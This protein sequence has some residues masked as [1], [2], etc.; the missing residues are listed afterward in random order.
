MIQTM[1]H[2]SVKCTQFIQNESH[3]HVILY[4]TMQLCGFEQLFL[5]LVD[6]Y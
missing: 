4:Q 6:K 1:L 2:I 5:D 3:N